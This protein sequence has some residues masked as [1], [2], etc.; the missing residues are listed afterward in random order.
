MLVL[1]SGAFAGRVPPRYKIILPGDRATKVSRDPLRLGCY[2]VGGDSGVVL[3]KVYTREA[4]TGE[5]DFY[6]DIRY[7]EGGEG[8]TERCMNYSKTTGCGGFG[9]W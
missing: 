9:S 7:S 1:W 3:D 5:F 4:L 6:L 8:G 2:R